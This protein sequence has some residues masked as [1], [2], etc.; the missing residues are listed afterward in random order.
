MT[1]QHQSRELAFNGLFVS[2]IYRGFKIQL[3]YSGALVFVYSRRY[4]QERE[5]LQGRVLCAW[6]IW[7]V[8]HDGNDFSQPLPVYLPG[9]RATITVTLCHGG[10]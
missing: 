6:A 2:D 1:S 7:P 8:R 10:I 5:Y 9:P 3:W 4:L